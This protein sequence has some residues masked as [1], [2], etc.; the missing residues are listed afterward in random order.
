M[1]SNNIRRILW[2]LS[3]EIKSS[4]RKFEYESKT[5]I[6]KECSYKFNEVKN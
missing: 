1:S 4:F 2:N 5:L 3:Q 6:K